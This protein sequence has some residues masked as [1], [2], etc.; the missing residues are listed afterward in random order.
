MT[1]NDRERI[2]LKEIISLNFHAFKLLYQYTPRIVRAKLNLQIWTAVTPYVGIY[3]SALI[4]EELAGNRNP[5]RLI[6]LVMV[7]LGSAAIVALVNA[8]LTKQKDTI[9]SNQFYQLGQI[10][11]HKL[12]SMDFAA[13]D[14]TK[15]HALLDELRRHQ[16]GGRWGIDRTY[17]LLNN[18]IGGIVTLLGG[19]TLT[20]TL[21]TKTVPENA[22]T[23][24]I[25][26]H[27]LFLVGLVAIMIGLTYLSALMTTKS[28]SVYSRYSKEYASSNIGF[29]FYLDRLVQKQ[30]AADVRIY[31]QEK[32]MHHFL[33]EESGVWGSNGIFA[34]YA[35]GSLGFY[36]AAAAAVSVV[37]TGI[38]YVYVCLKAWAGAFGVGQITQYVAA[39]TKVASG[40]SMLILSLGDMRNNVPF[41][42]DEFKFLDI[43]NAMYQ[44][45]IPI[46]KRNDNDYEIVF[47]NVSFKY[48]SSENYALKDVSFRF[49]VGQRLA[50]VGM[51]GSGKTTMIKLL[52]RLY[53]PTEGHITL[54]GIDIRKYDYL[55]YLSVFSVVFQDFKLFSFE[56]GENVAGGTEYDAD[57]VRDCLVKAGLGERLKELPN[58]LHTYLYKDFDKEGVDVSGGEA[59]KIA[60]ARA[61]YK[62]A[63]FIILD[64]PTAALDPIAEAE[65]YSKF[66]EIVGDKTAIYISHRL[67]SCRFCD[68]IVV[69][70]H[71]AV[72]QQ[73]SHDALLADEAGKYH[74]LWY[75]QAQYYV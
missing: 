43:P 21:F 65:I 53:D 38:T 3:L 75:A 46:E 57:R 72:I 36:Q 32:M 10:H 25:L 44:G 42:K 16:Q 30:Y 6:M 54:N 24:T 73:G 5:D 37:F 33:D 14:D 41:L 40:L 67:S 71:G 55:E 22:G 15:T 19:F 34:R 59:Q 39:L 52:C 12:F 70:D 27:P 58:G 7:A 60:I 48:P 56:L 45:T 74:E 64:E 8:W 1:K 51:N 49:K 68:E 28:R 20:I 29:T 26:N 63:P 13:I 2:G 11:T 35:R 61:L 62:D 47:H 69:F 9:C 23:W 31:R 18:F 17:L 50:V 66:N 4:I